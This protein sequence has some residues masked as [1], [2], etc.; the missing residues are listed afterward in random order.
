MRGSL[1]VV[2]FFCIGCA[3]GV[4]YQVEFDTH[5][6]SMMIL[7]ALMLQVGI[8]IGSNKNLKMIIAHL[9]PKMLMIP[10]G[11]IVGTLLF[12][13]LASLLL[14]RWSVFEC[15]AVGSGFAY[16]SLSSLLIMQ[17]KEP[18]IGVQLASEL[19]TIALLANIFRE[20]MALLGTPLIQKYFGRFAIISAAG[21]NSMD[22]LLPSITRY[23]G[24]EMIPL[25]IL[26]GILIDLSVPI[27][28][29]YFCSL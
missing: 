11:T 8:S 6:I 28:V 10:L 18:S 14:S 12:S 25:A 26:H 4:F 5:H 23:S 19:A 1:R 13:A 21:V 9:R 27:F 3:V 24:K 7:Y 15:M 22:V 17:F 20:M 29:S 16:Y 2:L